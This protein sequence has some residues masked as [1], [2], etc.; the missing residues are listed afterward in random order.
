PPGLVFGLLVSQPQPGLLL[1]VAVIA[2][3]RWTTFF[4]AAATAG[5]A[6]V[7]SILVF[8]L[9][10]WRAFFDLALPVQTAMMDRGTGPFL[11][12]M[13]SVFGGMR[14]LGLTGEAIW[15]QLPFFLFAAALTWRAFRSRRSPADR[16]AIVMLATFV[17]TPQAFGY[18]LIPA[19]A[20]A[21]VFAR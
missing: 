13:T 10:P 11:W 15:L 4:A 18:D 16:A 2:A 3:R 6:V 1:P 19:A 20:A 21:L 8:G 9:E 5:A 12:M 7:L 14:L 17:A